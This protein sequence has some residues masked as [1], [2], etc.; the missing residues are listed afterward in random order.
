MKPKTNSE[1]WLQKIQTNRARDAHTDALLAAE[2]WLSVRVWEHE[3]PS[4][5]AVK[6][7]R[8]IGRRLSA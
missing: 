3:D 6:I 1:F 4:I 2:G 7:E 5:A 8:I